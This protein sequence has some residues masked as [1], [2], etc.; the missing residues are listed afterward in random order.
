VCVCRLN[1]PVRNNL[2]T[3][4]IAVY[5]LSI[6]TKLYIAVYGLS[7]GTKLYIAVYGLSIGTTLYI[8]VYGL[9]IGTKLYIA[10]Y[11]LSKGT[12]LYI[13]VYGLSIGTILYIAVY[14]LSIGTKSHFQKA[15]LLC[16]L[17]K[18]IST[19]D[20][21]MNHVQ[22]FVMLYTSHTVTP[23]NALW[24]HSQSRSD[25]CHGVHFS[26]SHTI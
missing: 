1:Y 5:G 12:K 23:F 15:D 24:S 18:R 10:V 2:A 14:G 7:I 13:V 6:G 21:K 4:Y 11:G 8:A 19:K 22:T 3:C 26:H 9:S 17:A 25:I 16:V 20:K